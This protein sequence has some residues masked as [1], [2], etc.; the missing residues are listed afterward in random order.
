MKNLRYRAL[1]LALADDA[2]YWLSLSRGAGDA[3][4][5]RSDLLREAEHAI[6]ELECALDEA[7][8]DKN[9]LM[10]LLQEPR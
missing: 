6:I 2:L 5:V 10:R 8:R 9:E 1:V 4:S 3:E 7:D